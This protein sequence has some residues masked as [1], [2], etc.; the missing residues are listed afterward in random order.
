MQ[1]VAYGEKDG[2]E[3]VDGY[4][5]ERIG[6]NRNILARY[7]KF[8]DTV[9]RRAR[10]VDVVYL[11]GPVSE[12]LPGTI[13]AMLAGKSTVMKVVGDY[14]WEMY[15]GTG[16]GEREA[17]N[18]ERGT[19]N[20][21]PGTGRKE[22]LDEFLTHRHVGTV[23]V[24]EW[25]ERWTAKRAIRMI[26]PSRY[27][28]SV[29]KAWGVPE[30]RIRV[31]Y[32]AAEPLPSSTMRLNIEGKRVMLTAVR[33][34][35]WKGVDFII[36]IMSDL[37]SDVVLVVAG[38]G[39]S[40]DDWKKLASERGVG[41]RVR[42]VGRLDRTALADWYRAADLFVLP[43]GYEGFPHV[44]PEA[45]SVG[46]PSF[47]SDKGGNPE[48]RELLGE[49]VR[50]LPYGDVGAWRTALSGPWPERTTPAVPDALRFETMVKKTLEAL[51]L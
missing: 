8:A 38:D 4:P 10:L 36:G 49:L 37:P 17:G 1:V 29:V 13:G 41:D 48:T 11:Q 50:V 16:N 40:L 23:R 20:G 22:L 46:L 44:V 12:G 28:A 24:L 6:R 14:A 47:V 35:P 45:A 33:C 15:Q 9:R 43:S 18:R 26:V 39:P 34:V 31:I 30:G 2:I 32:N 51:N 21:E 25:I 42:F 7:W 3:H 27:L 19:G 5:V